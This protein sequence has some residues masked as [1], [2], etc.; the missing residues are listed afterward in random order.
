M[1]E[2]GGEESK[3]WFLVRGKFFVQYEIVSGGGFMD[4]PHSFANGERK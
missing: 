2:V 3:S 4:S 1:R